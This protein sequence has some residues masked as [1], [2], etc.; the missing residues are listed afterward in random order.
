MV[1]KRKLKTTKAIPVTTPTPLTDRVERMVKDL[2]TPFMAFAEG[3][4]ALTTARSDLAP[5]FMKTY[6]AWVKETRG[7]FAGFVRTFDPT[8][9][10]DRAG[11][12]KHSTYR[13]ADYL[14][15]LSG[16]RKEAPLPLD[17]R[18]LTP[19]VALARLIATVMPAVDPTGVIWNAFLKEM[20]WSDQQAERLKV[21]A[22]KEGAI[23]LP[24]RTKHTLTTLQRA[25]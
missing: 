7:T 25:A 11:Y 18:P 19:M 5:T 14:R 17:K 10:M 8:V 23:A 2:A 3:F 9:P 15:R 24:P 12:R 13:S 22:A 20:R 6:R 16:R 21:M 4:A 1:T